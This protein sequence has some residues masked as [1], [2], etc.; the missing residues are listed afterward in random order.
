VE[1]VDRLNVRGRDLT[2]G[3]GTVKKIP[4]QRRGG[5]GLRLEMLRKRGGQRVPW[6]MQLEKRRYNRFSGYKKDRHREVRRRRG[7]EG[8]SGKLR[9]KVNHTRTK[10]DGRRKQ[11]QR[12]G[13]L[14][15][16]LAHSR[17]YIGRKGKARKRL[18]RIV[19]E[20]TGE[21]ARKGNKN[22][23]SSVGRGRV[24]TGK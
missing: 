17:K 14:G 21:E 8:E 1:A 20:A 13:K 9:G 2:G 18:N 10:G 3:R 11:R 15:G 7:W 4:L 12:F 19:P 24:L 16:E 23:T 5:R 22:A 6:S